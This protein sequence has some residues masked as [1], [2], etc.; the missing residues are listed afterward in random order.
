[1]IAFPTVSNFKR[2]HHQG[3]ATH[4]SFVELSRLVEFGN[5]TMCLSGENNSDL[6]SSIFTEP[7]TLHV[8][9]QMKSKLS[10]LGT[11]MWLNVQNNPQVFRDYVST[12]SG[13]SQN[14][15]A[16]DEKKSDIVLLEQERAAASGY[17]R[18][19]AC[20]LILI[21]KIRT[22]DLMVP[23]LVMKDGGAET[24]T[25]NTKDVAA[26]PLARNG[27]LEFAFKCLSR[28]GRAMLNYSSSVTT[29]PSIPDRFDSS[30][31]YTT[32]SLALEFWS[33][34]D[35]IQK[36]NNDSSKKSMFID[37]VFDVMLLL[38]DCLLSLKGSDGSKADKASDSNLDVA[39]RTLGQLQR[40]EDFVNEQIS[41]TGNIPNHD[42]RIIQQFL[43]SIARLSYKVS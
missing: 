33:S 42:L 4:C 43:P 20:R 30:V 37:E 16:Q 26:L 41:C 31:A 38:P 21:S 8:D 11:N 23:K 40:L 5:T 7:I 14:R 2:L 25:S 19:L 18:S 13:K 12:S 29:M 27:E 15:I 35:Q 39:T 3:S 32:L 34:L 10:S 1:M 9:E 22:K 28:A 24:K 36:M 6:P 17:I